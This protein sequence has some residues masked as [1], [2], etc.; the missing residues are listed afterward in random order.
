MQVK[1]WFQNRRAK[2]KR[3]KA[4]IVHGSNGSPNSGILSGL[5]SS[6]GCGG[7]RSGTSKIVVPIPV[8]VTRQ[9]AMRNQVLLVVLCCVFRPA[10]A[11]YCKRLHGQKQWKHTQKKFIMHMGGSHK[12]QVEKRKKY[13]GQWLGVTPK[14]WL[15]NS[16]NI[17]QFL[18]DINDI[19]IVLNC[20][21]YCIVSFF[22]D[23]FIV[24]Y[25]FLSS[26]EKTC[27]TFHWWWYWGHGGD[28]TPATSPSCLVPMVYR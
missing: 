13:N 28:K 22:I 14:H 23:S 25:H 10:N 1:I 9:F 27:I 6:S 26:L 18:K 15:P 7:S 8:H 3:V 12:A 16:C 11:C 2:W 5:G 4:G 21:I 24:W 19:F 20:F 17:I